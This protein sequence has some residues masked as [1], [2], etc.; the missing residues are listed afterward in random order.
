MEEQNIKTP[1]QIMAAAAIGV[2]KSIS[3]FKM[4]GVEIEKG[5]VIT[6]RRI[7][8]NRVLYTKYCELWSI[9]PDLFVDV[10]TPTSSHFKLLFYQRLFLRA[11]MRHGRCGVIAPRAFSKS[12]ISIFGMY[13]MCIFRPGIKLFIC[14]PGK[15]QSAKIA[16]EKIYEIWELFPLLRNE[17][18]GEGNFSG[19]YVRLTFRCG[20]VFDVVSPL[21]SQRGGRRGAGILDEYRD[22]EADDLN[23]IVLPLLNVSRPTKNGVINE[24]EPHQVQIWLSSAGDKN[25]FCYDK[26]IELMEL[27]IINP[28]K[29]FLFGC[30]YRLPLFCGLLPKDYL[31]EIKTSGT[32]SETSFAK[33]YMSRFVGSS[34]EAWFDYEK[35]KRLRKIVNP[36]N[37]EIVREDLETFY[38][39]SV[40]LARR[41]CQS[42]ATVL[43]V[44]PNNLNPWRI[45]LVNLFILGKTEQEKVFDKQVLELKKMI[46]RYNPR[47][48]VIDINGI[49]INFADAMV[50]ETQ[51][52][53]TLITYPAYAFSNREEYYDIQPRNAP[54]ILYGIKATGQLNSDMH[55]TLYSKVYSGLLQFLISEQEAKNKLMATKAGQKMSPEQR[56]ERLM[57]HELTSILINEIMNLKIKPTGIGNQIAVE[58]INKRMTKDKFSALEMGVWRISILEN[59]TLSRRR[60]RG[61]DGR[62]GSRKL[63]FWRA[64]GGR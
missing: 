58:Q 48:V 53:E 16:R 33:E 43:K 57:P 15:A 51:D 55:A 29:C 13:L 28:S 38:I 63:T 49:G 30:D 31:N 39:I 8:Q 35:F 22:H 45:K 37:H 10:I 12:F 54:Q 56:I 11:I 3:T 47:E 2:Q 1:S 24:K 41:G 9:Y 23:E 26:T 19:D 14:A 27:S 64:G 4:F 32:F 21:N 18:I 20:S 46:A 52:P 36:E 44:F 25:S 61:L 60:N 59:E 50:K 6:G 42:V 5:A 62:G 7:E 34:N 40:D 17:I